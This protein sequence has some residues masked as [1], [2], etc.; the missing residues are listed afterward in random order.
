MRLTPGSLW[1]RLHQTI[2]SWPAGCVVS[3]RG[4]STDPLNG[5]DRGY[6]RPALRDP[7]PH[8]EA[9]L[10]QSYL[11]AQSLSMS[12]A[13]GATHCASTR[14]VRS[15]MP[16][17]RALRHHFPAARIIR[18]A[19][20]DAKLAKVSCGLSPQ[21]AHFRNTNLLA[22]KVF[23]FIAFLNSDRM[24]VFDSD[25]IFFAEPTTY[26]QRI[27]D[28]SYRC[29]TFNARCGSRLHVEPDA[30]RTHTSVMTCS[31]G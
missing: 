5:A 26:L 31:P 15:R 22:P 6:H 10:A 16:H 21:S 17:S 24:A 4:A 2:W 13:A 12:Q 8:L 19:E 14:M 30:V 28:R 1:L 29:N 9:G 23:D 25:L 11:D 27:E 20:A 7:C 3:R 18:R